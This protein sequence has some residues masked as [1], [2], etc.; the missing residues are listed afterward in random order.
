MG[1]GAQTGVPMV[2]R[3]WTVRPPMESFAFL[4]CGY[5]GEEFFHLPQACVGMG[6]EVSVDGCARQASADRYA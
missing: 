2:A 6:S 1:L 3:G 4:E 5:E